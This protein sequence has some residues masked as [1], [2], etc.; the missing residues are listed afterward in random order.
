M[1]PTVERHTVLAKVAR[2][3]ALTLFVIGGG[4]LAAAAAMSCDQPKPFCIVTPA[5][6]A[7]RL[8][9]DKMEGACDNFGPAGFNADP[10]VGISPYYERDDKGQPDY[11]RGSIAM[12][13]GEVGTLEQTAA[14]RKVE[15]SASGGKTYSMGEFAQAEPTLS[16][17]H[18]VLEELPAVPDDEATPDDDESLPGQPAQDITL[19][20]SDVKIVVSAALF[21]SQMQGKLIDTRV[22]ADGESCTITY[23]AIGLSPAVPCF[24]ED[25]N[26]PIK[27]DDGTFEIDAELCN[28]EANPAKGRFAGSG[29]SPLSDT[30]CDDVTGYCLL[31]GDSVP[32][33]K[34]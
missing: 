7:V 10:T 11:R 16:E 24:R 21:G 25:D 27:K 3:R 14:D 1:G 26:G 18:L 12:R 32:A 19:K 22:G 6:F 8:K 33:Y 2:G 15:N 28:P 23:S 17:T 20:W 31:R 5:P 4:V 29:I 13:T 9:M 34:E 30:E